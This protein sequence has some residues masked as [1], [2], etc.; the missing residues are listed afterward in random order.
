[1]IRSDL[2]Q[3]MVEL[4]D[5]RSAGKYSYDFSWS[6][7]YELGARYL[8]FD[9]LTHSFLKVDE[10]VPPGWLSV[11]EEKIDQ[12]FSVYRLGADT[13]PPRPDVSCREVQPGLWQPPPE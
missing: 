7:L 5:F 10:K 8:V 4:A 11:S 13:G 12:R 3:C 6:H 2:L 9:R 1:M